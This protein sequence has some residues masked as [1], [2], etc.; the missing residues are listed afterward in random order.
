M[1]SSNLEL[2]ELTRR[3]FKDIMRVLKYCILCGFL[4][5]SAKHQ[6]N[7]RLNSRTILFENDEIKQHHQKF[8]DIWTETDETEL[9]S[10]FRNTRKAIWN[11]EYLN[12]LIGRSLRGKIISKLKQKRNL[13]NAVDGKILYKC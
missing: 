2:I 11:D 6:R 12:K 5:I 9:D 3:V 13:K 8:I 1:G 10:E 4:A 7:P